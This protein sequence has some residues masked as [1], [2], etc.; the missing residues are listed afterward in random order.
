MAVTP[1]GREVCL[2]CYKNYIQF[3]VKLKHCLIVKETQLQIVHLKEKFQ[4]IIYVKRIKL[5]ILSMELSQMLLVLSIVAVVILKI[6]GVQKQNPFSKAWHCSSMYY[7]ARRIRKVDSETNLGRPE[8]IITHAIVLAA[9]QCVSI[10]G[11]RMGML[12]PCPR[13]FWVPI[14]ISWS[15]SIRSTM[16]SYSSTRKLMN[17]FPD[18]K[19]I[20]FSLF[21]GH[22]TIAAQ[23]VSINSFRW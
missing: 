5:V 2:H 15:P 7:F 21:S 3:V 11:Q 9:S 6:L 8:T 1:S 17:S 16:L 14:P 4:V 22:G 12:H 23:L 18:P 20:Y 13:L 10:S 19:A